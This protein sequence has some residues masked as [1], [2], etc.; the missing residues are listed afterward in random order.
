MISSAGVRSDKTYEEREGTSQA[1]AVAAAAS[2]VV[3]LEDPNLS[4]LELIARLKQS[5]RNIDP[6]NPRFNA[7][8]GAGLLDLTAALTED[9][10]VQDSTEKRLFSNPQGYLN[11]F[12]TGSSSAGWAIQPQSDFDGI[13]LFSWLGEGN[14]GESKIRIY[15]QENG[16]QALVRELE[17]GE[18]F[19]DIYVPGISAYVILSDGQGIES[20]TKW[21]L[22][23]RAVP[24]DYSRLYCRDTVSIYEE[25][26]IEDGSGEE[27]YSYDSDCKWLITAPE[28]MVVKIRFTE[29]DTEA[30]TDLVYFF[31]GSGTHEDIMAI[32]SGPNIPPELTTWSNQ[33]LVWFVTDSQNQ[34]GGWKAEIQFQPAEN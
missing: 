28:G 31:N 7:K 16:R 20:N 6:L 25:A 26:I 17:L 32:F 18:I 24:I 14:P 11:L 23:Y 33:V 15:K 19:T 5:A 9:C 1:A 12:S 21:L 27:N 22:E 29:F 13:R 30:K 4:S 2:A 8:L 10:M 34:H 3:L